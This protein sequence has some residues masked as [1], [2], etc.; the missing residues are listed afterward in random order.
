MASLTPQ[1]RRYR[2][3]TAEILYHFPEGRFFEGRCAG[4]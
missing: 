1:L 3:T 2:L 4:P